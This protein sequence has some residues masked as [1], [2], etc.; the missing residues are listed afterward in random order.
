MEACSTHVGPFQKMNTFQCPCVLAQARRQ[1]ESRVM[2]CHSARGRHC[3]AATTPRLPRVT[4]SNVDLRLPRVTQSNVD[5]ETRL[6]RYPIQKAMPM[7]YLKTDIG[8]PSSV[9]GRQVLAPSLK[10]MNGLEILLQ[11]GGLTANVCFEEVLRCMLATQVN[12]STPPRT[13][14]CLLSACP[15]H[16]TNVQ[17]PRVMFA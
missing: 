8:P 11:Y 17:S 16:S 15:R 5:L 13:L 12:S 2:R 4:P 9:R 3:R 14:D 1:Q 6:A 7:L 10:T